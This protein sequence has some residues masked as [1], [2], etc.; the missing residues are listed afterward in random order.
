LIWY[1]IFE[2]DHENLLHR[3]KSLKLTVKIQDCFRKQIL[4]MPLASMTPNHS[5]MACTM[6]DERT[7]KGE[8]DEDKEERKTKHQYH[9]SI[10]LFSKEIFR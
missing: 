5:D 3:K 2:I 8:K 10:L 1:A 9:I 4:A 7:Q 6:L